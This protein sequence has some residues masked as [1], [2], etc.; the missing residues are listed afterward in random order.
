MSSNTYPPARYAEMS[1]QAFGTSSAPL[2]PAMHEQIQ[3]VQNA[4]AQ[5]PE[6]EAVYRQHLYEQRRHM[7]ELDLIPAE[8]R[9][10]HVSADSQAVHSGQIALYCSKMEDEIKL[11]NPVKYG[12]TNARPLVFF[13]LTNMT[14]EQLRDTRFIG[15]GK[16]ELL[17][18]PVLNQ[19]HVPSAVTV[20][21][22]G[23]CTLD[24]NTSPVEVRFG[25]NLFWTMHDAQGVQQNIMEPGSHYGFPDVIPINAVNNTAMANYI[26]NYPAN[27]MP[28]R[29]QAIV[30]SILKTW[31]QMGYTAYG[32]PDTPLVVQDQR[33][34][35]IRINPAIGDV[36]VQ[37]TS[38]LLALQQF[39]ATHYVG[40]SVVQN[41]ARSTLNIHVCPF[42]TVM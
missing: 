19:R 9:S 18:R 4:H 25:D 8:L 2:V 28:Q 27:N 34:G 21:T 30:R 32:D 24:Y 5:T 36:A 6:A 10:A 33:G 13:S 7:D 23:I 17:P 26:A 22:F 3:Q 40:K 1:M 11:M 29:E 42:T 14:H 20:V 35:G 41:K 31:M 16:N 37:L 38:V 39:Q 15:V 12:D